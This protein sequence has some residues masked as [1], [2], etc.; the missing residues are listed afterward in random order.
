MGIRIKNISG[1]TGSYYPQH[2]T[3][4][5]FMTAIGAYF[6]TTGNLP[7]R[8]ET[9]DILSGLRFQNLNIDQDAKINNATIFVRTLWTFDPGVA[10]VTIYGID[11]NDAYPFNSSG[12]FTRPYTTE[13]VNWN[14]TEVTGST[15]HNV[16]VT[17]IVQEIVSRYGWRSGNS[18]AFMIVCPEGSPR[19]EFAT[20]DQNIVYRS[21]LDI[22]YEV[23]PPSPSDDAPPPYND[24][25]VWV[26]DYRNSTHGYDI[27]RVRSYGDP[28][29]QFIGG[30]IGTSELW[31]HNTTKG[32][33]GEIKISDNHVLATWGGLD[34][35]LGLD[36][37]TLALIDNGSLQIQVTNDEFA[38]YTLTKPNSAYSNI[39]HFGGNMG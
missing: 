15:W 11:E 36:P 13:Y 3:D 19:R 37:W 24:T 17:K 32:R 33:G 8:S 12:D 6:G 5:A 4:D 20:I 21:R 7:L 26:W 35:I 27:F 38:T 34:P 2:T 31:Y 16:S 1:D 18:I 22:T 14:V 39:A 29:V 9:T 23:A 28:E 25:D 10:S 30:E